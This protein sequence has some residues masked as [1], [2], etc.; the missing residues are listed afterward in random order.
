[1][2]ITALET[3]AAGAG[4]RD[5]CFV[6]LSTDAGIVGW[7]EYVEERNIGI[8]AV[9]EWLGEEIVGE[10]PLPFELLC[11]R[12]RAITRHVSGGIAAQ[13]IAAVENALLDIKGKVRAPTRPRDHHATPTTLH[14][15]S[16]LLV[17]APW[18]CLTLSLRADCRST[19]GSRWPRSSAAPSAPRSPATGPTPALSESGSTLTSAR[20]R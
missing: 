2:I 8:T 1:M 14:G 17:P 12:L 18:S 7:S 11:Q 4:W 19:S 20:S 6:K 16:R 15:R 5:F 10:D 13:A 9:I 3:L